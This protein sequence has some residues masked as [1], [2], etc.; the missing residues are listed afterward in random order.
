MKKLKIERAEGYELMDS[1]GNPTVGARVTLSDGS[2]GFA[3]RRRGLQRANSRLTKDGTKTPS[4]TEV[5]GSDRL[6]TA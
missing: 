2:C 3:L 1:R 6:L 4:V 5:R